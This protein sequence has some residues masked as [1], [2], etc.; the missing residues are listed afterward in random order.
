MVINPTDIPTIQPFGHV[1]ADLLR[2]LGF[3]VELVETDWSSVV[4]RRSNREP[5]QRGGWNIFHT[6]WPGVAII[7]P[8]VTAI[9]RGQGDQGWFGWYRNERVEELTARWLAAA[10]P[11]EQRRL[12]DEIGRESF[13]AVPT[14]PLGQFFIRTAYRSNLTG[15]LKGTSPYPWNVQKA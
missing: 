10:E 11:A 9:L 12:A 15:V 1:T 2:R 3:D 4:Q 6:W 13:E 7:N 5:P 8:A 14:L